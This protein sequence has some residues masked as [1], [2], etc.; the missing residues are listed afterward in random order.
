MNLPWF[1]YI[2]K[3][4]DKSLYTGVTNNIA[5]RIKSHNSGTASKYTRSR[6]PVKLVFLEKHNTKNSALKREKAIKNWTRKYKEE[7][8][9]KQNQKYLLKY[10]S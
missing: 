4:S 9:S 3:C 2:V 6:L 5:R 1:V 10:I 8:I 7:L